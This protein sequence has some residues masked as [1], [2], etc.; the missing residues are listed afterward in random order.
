[1]PDDISKMKSIVE[2][3]TLKRPSSKIVKQKQ[4]AAIAVTPPPKILPLGQYM[5]Y[6][7]ARLTRWDFTGLWYKM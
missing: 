7:I 6:K 4:T 5:G 3:R 2:L 1:M